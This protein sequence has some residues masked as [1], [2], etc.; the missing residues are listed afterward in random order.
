[1]EEKAFLKFKNSIRCSTVQKHFR[2][3]S[4]DGDNE[5]ELGMLPDD[6]VEGDQEFLVNVNGIICRD[7]YGELI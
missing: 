6:Y 1:M 3:S 5:V 4:V 2:H 7:S